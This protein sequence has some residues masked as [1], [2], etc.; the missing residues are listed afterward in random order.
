MV[1]RWRTWVLSSCLGKSTEP[2]QVKTLGVC[3]C[4]GYWPSLQSKRNQRRSLSGELNSLREQL[5]CWQPRAKAVCRRQTLQG[6]FSLLAGAPET[7][8]IVLRDFVI[9]DSQL[10]RKRTPSAFIHSIFKCTFCFVDRLYICIF[11]HHQTVGCRRE[12][13]GHIHSSLLPAPFPLQIA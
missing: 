7:E 13:Q 3:M 1:I 2:P 4:H 5:F 8:G 11:F 12:G 6:G 10:S 9:S